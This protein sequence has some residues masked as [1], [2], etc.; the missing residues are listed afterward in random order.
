[1]TPAINDDT[2]RGSPRRPTGSDDRPLESH[3][4]D[5]ARRMRAAALD[6]V[7]FEEKTPLSTP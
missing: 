1:V 3:R 2:P 5:H 7:V 6:R 4:R